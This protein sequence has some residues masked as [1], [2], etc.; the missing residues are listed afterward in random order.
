M[1]GI[2]RN[3]IIKL[4]SRHRQGQ[5]PI[6][7]LTNTIYGFLLIIVILYTKVYYVKIFSRSDRVSLFERFSIFGNLIKVRDLI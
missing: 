1:Y 7:L 5:P 6:K 4:D 3:I 2:C